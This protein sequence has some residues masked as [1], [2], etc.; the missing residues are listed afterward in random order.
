VSAISAS[1]Y[2]KS[3]KRASMQAASVLGQRFVNSALAYLLDRAERLPYYD[4]V[5][6]VRRAMVLKIHVIYKA[7]SWERLFLGAGWGGRDI[8]G[9]YLSGAEAEIVIGNWALSP[10]IPTTVKLTLSVSNRCEVDA[11]FIRASSA[12]GSA[13]I[14]LKRNE[15]TILTLPNILADS[16]HNNTMI[17]LKPTFGADDRIAA[18]PGSIDIVALNELQIIR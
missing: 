5:I 17:I 9:P 6:K 3:S 2:K 11:L 18:T 7:P 4:L 13:Q 15:E 14:L 12:F 10:K 8:R 1:N 16:V